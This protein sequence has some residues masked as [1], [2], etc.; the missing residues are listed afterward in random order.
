VQQYHEAA[1]RLGLLETGGTDWHGRKDSGIR[2]GVGRGQ[3]R[4][5]YSVVEAMRSRLA[6]RRR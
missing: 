2:L 6:G 4:I 3:M 1:A 5:R